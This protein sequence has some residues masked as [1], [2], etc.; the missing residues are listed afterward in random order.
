V[1]ALA[2]LGLLA[3]TGYV[4]GLE[5]RAGSGAYLIIGLVGGISAIAII[6]VRF[7]SRHNHHHRHF[8]PHHHERG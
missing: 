7:A 1:A 6:T 4:S 5:S 8:P 3:F 2:Y